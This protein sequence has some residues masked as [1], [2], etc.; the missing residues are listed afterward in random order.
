MFRRCFFLFIAIG[1][2]SI[3]FWGFEIESHSKKIQSSS[4]GHSSPITIKLFVDSLA[5]DMLSE[6]QKIEYD[7]ISKHASDDLDLCQKHYAFWNKR[8]EGMGIVVANYYLGERALLLNDFLDLKK[9]GL[10][11]LDLLDITN[12][13]SLKNLFVQMA[14]NYLLHARKIKSIN[15]GVENN[16]EYS[17]DDSLQIA[18]AVTDLY[19]IQPMQGITKLKFYSM[20]DTSL[21]AIKFLSRAYLQIGKNQEALHILNI[22]SKKNPNDIILF[23]YMAEVYEKVNMKQEAKQIYEKLW[24]SWRKQLPSDLGQIMQKKIRDLS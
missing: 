17:V 20:K 9:A 14:R 22:A 11:F 13:Q 16:E 3:L 10:F 15:T 2:F 24:K 5:H 1:L 23:L 7:S 4:V 18:L 12:K 19:G 8:L 21:Y 6:K